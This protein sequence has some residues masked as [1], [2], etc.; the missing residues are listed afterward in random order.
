MM[1]EKQ[2]SNKYNKA[3][4]LGTWW[5]NDIV[6]SI[7]IALDLQK[8]GIQTD[9]AGVLSPWAVHYFDGQKE[10]PIN[11]IQGDVKRFINSKSF[12]EISFV[13][14]FLPGIA[15]K[16]G[17]NISNYYDLSTR[18][19]TKKL[20]QEM[21][22]L[23]STNQY[24]LFVAADVWWDILARWKEDDTLLSPMMD[25]TSL[26][27]L[28]TL[29]IDTYLEEFWLLTDGELRRQWAQIILND[30]I[31]KSL[32]LGQDKLS[33]QDE[34]IQTF[35]KIFDEIKKIRSWHTWVIT[36]QTLEKIWSY[37]DLITQY[38]F[39][40]QIGKQI[41]HTAFDVEIPYQYFAKTY[42]IDWKKFATE[43]KATAFEYENI[44]DQYIRLK[45]LQKNRKTEM[46]LFYLRSWDNWTTP[47]Q[48]WYC[49]QFLVPSTMIPQQ[50]RAAMLQA[51]ISQ[52]LSWETD[53]ALISH[54]DL[55]LVPYYD[56]IKIKQAWNFCLVYQKDIEDF[57]DSSLEQ[58]KKYQS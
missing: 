43:R 25:F 10:Q 49:M 58:I 31:A 9:I 35:I 57:I 7:I 33:L 55:A 41:W 21:D 50:E 12:K 22:N 36:L 29:D 18:F 54:D 19:W 48:K 40:S 51:W 30:L 8:K 27:L 37:E 23:I 44:L 16:H 15:A 5:W 42:L 26:N 34:N 32:L 47:E 52:L 53:L 17:V 20:S 38:R 4:I 28:K 13:D 14:G 3:L 56:W 24:D 45:S 1:F 39:R 2:F 11:R 6:S 46:D